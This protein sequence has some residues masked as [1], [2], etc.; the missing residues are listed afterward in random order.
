MKW[1]GVA[2]AVTIVA[3]IVTGCGDDGGTG[4]PALDAEIELLANRVGVSDGEMRCVLEQL[5]PAHEDELL[6]VAI[7]RS[8]A[9]CRI[10]PTN[11][12]LSPL[13]VD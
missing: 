2:A 10:D 1:R 6:E 7:A 4:D 8:L 3:M 5:A 11:I 13:G 12:D 9:R